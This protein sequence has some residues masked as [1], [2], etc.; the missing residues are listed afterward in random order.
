MQNNSKIILVIQLWETD[1]GRTIGGLWLAHLA[2]HQMEVFLIKIS[3]SEVKN[4]FSSKCWPH[5]MRHMA[6]E[7]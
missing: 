2:H 4:D 6:A 1:N 3:V 5:L 7:P